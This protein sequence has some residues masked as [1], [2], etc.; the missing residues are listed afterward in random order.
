[1]QWGARA[2]NGRDKMPYPLLS[3]FLSLS[4]SLSPAPCR[5]E[6]QGKKDERDKKGQTNQKALK[7][8]RAHAFRRG[9]I[10]VQS[11]TRLQ[12]DGM[13]G[14]QPACLLARL[15]PSGLERNAD[16]GCERAITGVGGRDPD[17]VQQ[18]QQL[19]RVDPPSSS[20]FLSPN[21][22]VCRKGSLPAV[23]SHSQQ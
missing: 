20:S 22:M 15:V 16:R 23:C 10:Y 2:E 8:T 1:M 18:Q 17:Q 11:S 3:C 12:D 14:F 4:Q 5:D 6:R 9:S 19:S 13:Q 7:P 21:K